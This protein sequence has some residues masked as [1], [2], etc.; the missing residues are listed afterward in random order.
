[1][2]A[3]IGTIQYPTALAIEAITAQWEVIN[4]ITA[5]MYSPDQLPD[6]LW[7]GSFIGP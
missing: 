3:D 5:E 6:R 2:T 1:M 4:F 7:S